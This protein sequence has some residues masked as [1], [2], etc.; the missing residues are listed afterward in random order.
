MAPDSRAT[1]AVATDEF[2]AL[3]RQTISRQNLC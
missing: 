3:R 1:E 2:E